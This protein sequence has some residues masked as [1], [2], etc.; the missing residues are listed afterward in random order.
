VKV[1]GILQR[2]VGMRKRLRR[3][4]TKVSIGCPPSLVLLF[5]LPLHIAIGVDVRA[6]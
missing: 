1:V 4:G 2:I 5:V 3:V 6:F